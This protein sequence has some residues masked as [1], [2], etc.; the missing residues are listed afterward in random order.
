MHGGRTICFCRYVYA[1][2]NDDNAYRRDGW[3]LLPLRYEPWLKFIFAF[4][5]TP[6]T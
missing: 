5:K 1:Y 6:S 3:G 2:A 4:Y